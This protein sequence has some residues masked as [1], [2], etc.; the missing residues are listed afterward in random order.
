M[1]LLDLLWRRAQTARLAAV[2]PSRESAIAAAQAA[3]SDGVSDDDHVAVIGPLEEVIG[4]DPPPSIR[5]AWAVVVEPATP[6]QRRRIVRALRH[7]LRRRKGERRAPE[8]ASPAAA[9]LIGNRS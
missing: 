6:A 8:S 7:P 4:N 9:G 1:K 3:K 5:G 2:Y